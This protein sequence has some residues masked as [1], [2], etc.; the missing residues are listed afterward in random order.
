MKVSSL[1]QPALKCFAF[2]GCFRQKPLPCCCFFRVEAQTTDPQTEWPVYP[3]LKEGY[4]ANAPMHPFSNFP[5][6]WGL[7]NHFTTYRYSCDRRPSKDT[8]T[9][10]SDCNSRYLFC[11]CGK[12]A[13]RV[14][15]GG[16]CVGMTDSDSACYC[17]DPEAFRPVCVNDVCQCLSIE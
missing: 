8:C 11:F 16:S 4:S 1:F 14:R 15:E 3:G 9:L 5:N 17:S 6:V 10:D 2:G 13:S 7:S 12:C